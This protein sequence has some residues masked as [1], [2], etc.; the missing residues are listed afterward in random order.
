MLLFKN[1]PEDDASD[2]IVESVTRLPETETLCL[3]DGSLP[4]ADITTEI[5]N[6]SRDDVARTV[7][8]N[9]YDIS[10]INDDRPFFW[11]LTR[12]ED[13]VGDWSR[14][15]EDTEIAFGERLLLVL[16]AIAC[17][18]AALFLWLPFLLTR[19]RRSGSEQIAPRPKAMADV[20]YVASIGLGFM[21]IKVS[22]IQRFSLLLGY[23]TLS[24]SVSLFTLLLATAIGARFS[25][26]I[27]L[28]FLMLLPV[29]LAHGVFLP[30]GID[31]ATFLTADRDENQRGRF[32]AWCWAVNGFFSVIGSSVTTVASLTFGFDRTVLIGIEP[33]HDL[34]L[35]RAE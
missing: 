1:A 12:F 23:P 22:M 33:A 7:D 3:P 9:E 21:F 5:I 18:V 10:S 2:R 30:A 35:V 19:R 11:H 4:A 6:G 13:V 29:G 14:S 31:R 25:G 24:L 15:F 27:G 16:I 26:R 34:E 32:V 17:F 20:A 8:N 28:V